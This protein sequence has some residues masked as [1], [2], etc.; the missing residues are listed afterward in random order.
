MIKTDEQTVTGVFSN[1]Q[2]L[3]AIKTGHIV[4]HPFIEDHVRGSS[5]DV[6]LGHWYYKTERQASQGIYNPLDEHDVNRYFDG[7]HHAIEHRLW[8]EKN[9]RKLFKG[10][11]EDHPIIVLKPGER[12]LAHT[13]EFIGIK[14]PGTSTM[15]ARSTW[16]RNC[17]LYTSD[18]AD[19]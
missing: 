17:L 19:D 12:I 4:Y 10:I 15:Q 16:G 18:A 2:I 1:Q 3:Q 6:T 5:I 14:P 9:G 7:P 11:P 8:A 13:H